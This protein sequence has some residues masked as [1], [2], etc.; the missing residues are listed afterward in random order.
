MTTKTLARIRPA[1]E[2]AIDAAGAMLRAGRLVAFPTETVYGLGA[3]A[4]NDRAVAAIFAAKGRPQFNPLIVHVRDLTEAETL[5]E[6]SPH[7]ARAGEDILAR[8]IDTGTAAQEGRSPFAAGER[9]TR[10]CCLART[11]QPDAQA[12]LAAARCPIAAPSA[13]RSGEVSPTTCR[14]HGGRPGASI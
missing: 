8:R 3:D 11:R 6:F 9:R 10:Y 2:A 1:D 5:A 4:A 13:N 7:R 12:L 14:S